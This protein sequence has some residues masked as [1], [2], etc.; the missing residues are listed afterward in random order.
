MQVGIVPLMPTPRHEGLLVGCLRALLAA[1]MAAARVHAVPQVAL[2]AHASEPA[3]SDQRAQESS[4]AA[5]A[6]VPSF[7]ASGQSQWSLR[8]AWGDP[9]GLLGRELYAI[10]HPT[11][12]QQL[13]MRLEGDVAPGV[14]ALADLD[15]VK[16][17]NLQ[18]IGIDV[19]W[20][21]TRTHLGDIQVRSESSYA[22]G[23]ATVKGVDAAL[24]LG[25][26]QLSLLAGRSRGIPASKTFYGTSSEET[27]R[28][29]PGTAS[30]SPPYVP[31]LEGATLVGD[32]RGAEGFRL[33]R[34]Y[35]PDFTRVWL[36]PADGPPSAAPAG[37][38]TSGCGEIPDDRTLQ[39]LLSDYGLG[40]LYYDASQPPGQKG[41]IRPV[42]LTQPLSG[43]PEEQ[44]RRAFFALIEGQVT[45]LLTA[46]GEQVAGYVL[47][48]LESLDLMR[49]HVEALV[50]RFNEENQRSG[51]DRLAYPFVRGSTLEREFLTKLRQYYRFAAGAGGHPGAA[52]WSPAVSTPAGQPAAAPVPFAWV[53]TC[54]AYREGL[55]DGASNLP[56]DAPGQTLQAAS[57]LYLLGN[58]GVQPDDL[59]VQVERAGEQPQEADVHGLSWTLFAEEGVLQ[60]DY[61]GTLDD[62]EAE[63]AALR[64][65]YRHA[66][67]RGIYALGTSVAAGSERVY[68]NG[69]LL[70]RD[71]DY[72]IDYE[73]GVLVVLRDVAPE[74]RL[75]VDF[76]YFRGGLGAATEYHRNVF[77]VRAQWTPDERWRLAA[78]VFF[79][80]DEPRPMVEPE[81]ARTMPNAHTVAALSG[82]YRAERGAAPGQ[83]LWAEFDAAF[84]RDVSPFDANQ[85]VPQP[86]EV[87]VVAGSRAG[88]PGGAASGSYVLLGHRGGLTV[89]RIDETPGAQPVWGLYTTAA[90]LSGL[91]VYAVA[92]IVEGAVSDG[93]WPDTSGSSSTPPGAW[94]A[95]TES[96]L[97]L[98]VNRPSGGG[99]PF[100]S[101]ANW[102]RRH[103]S[104]GLPS[105][106]VR[107]VLYVGVPTR[108]PG[109]LD[110]VQTSV[111]VA[112]DRGVAWADAEGL[113]AGVTGDALRDWHTLDATTWPGAPP[114]EVLDLA[115]L[116]DGQDAMRH[117]VVA[118]TP[119]GVVWIPLSQ[120]W[121]EGWDAV[122]HVVPQGG[123]T[124]VA[125]VP[126]PGGG[127]R[128]W[129]G[130]Q[131]GL[132]YVD[133]PGVGPDPGQPRAWGP[134][135]PVRGLQALTSEAGAWW[136]LWVAA[137]SGIYRVGR[138][139]DEPE[140]P[141]PV[142][143]DPQ[144]GP[145]TAIGALPLSGGPEVWA[146]SR[147]AS[148]QPQVLRSVTGA[149]FEPV[150]LHQA[151]LPEGDPARF[152]DPLSPEV[153]QGMAGRVAAGY[154]WQG[155]GFDLSY[156]RVDGRF[157][158]INDIH[159][160]A[161][162]T[163]QAS[164]RH[165][166]TPELVVELSHQDRWTKLPLSDQA[167]AGLAQRTLADH[168]ALTWTPPVPPPFAWASPPALRGS[169]RWERVDRDLS[170]PEPE[171]VTLRRTLQ[172]QESFWQ[173]RLTASVGYEHVVR[174]ERGS[175]ATG[176]DYV[177][178]DLVA[179]LSVAPV[180]EVKLSANFRYPLR[181]IGDLEQP[182]AQRLQGTQSLH[183]GATASRAFGPVR[184]SLSL[185]QQSGW[186]LSEDG[187]GFEGQTRQ[188][189]LSVAAPGMS[190]GAW[191]LSPVG[192]LEWSQRDSQRS[193][194][195][196]FGVGGDLQAAWQPVVTVEVHADRGYELAERPLSKQTME[197][198]VEL[199]ARTAAWNGFDPSLTLARQVHHVAALGGY[200]APDGG[201]ERERMHTVDTATLRVGWR[202]G[203][204]WPQTS[205]IGARWVQGPAAGQGSRSVDAAHTFAIQPGGPWA[206]SWTAGA[207]RG[208]TWQAGTAPRPIWRVDLSG[209]ASYGFS[210][211][212]TGGLEA[213]YT[214][215]LASSSLGWAAPSAAA[216]DEAPFRTGWVRLFV[217]ATF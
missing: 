189:T 211:E 167:G 180:P 177:A 55:G 195:S 20:G 30:D 44:V 145:A 4:E 204:S 114:E 60:V 171:Q 63:F 57:V 11:F 166:P 148:G 174:D 1:C 183:V 65:R 131:S 26:W 151:S 3:P 118:A 91:T 207:S 208:E 196:T 105:N 81:R 129:I 58:I 79:E 54:P 92:P 150:S 124:R 141:V 98:I 45:G 66:I 212:W 99:S 35:D 29:V 157:L 7:R 173:H 88:Q 93:S 41:V 8:Y 101:T 202:L 24:D 143:A 86:N 112:T 142:L 210:T 197:D 70:K 27:V 113:A 21:P 122:R 187:T 162:E 111:W 115:F 175:G 69:E 165:Q 14:S 135:G 209:R 213:G 80:G 193:G 104:S 102:E 31:S 56:P 169:A 34:P 6:F 67:S 140:L 38:V 2:A 33:D 10:G 78:E 109:A 125:A 137:D 46:P 184:T 75:Q 106:Q 90:G 22:V 103:T 182:Q 134:V 25:P 168:V 205:R 59:S 152:A 176:S 62:F 107:D 130:S 188:A 149:T 120:G 97:T 132:Q 96:G 158:A 85:R 53:G 110:P 39:R 179:D 49:A 9:A 76:E 64:V 28:F 200:R 94:V 48:G 73:S 82:A 136:D 37:G 89:G 155:G 144:A 47:L 178:H 214:T 68:L 32:L 42:D 138:A 50:R 161:F 199:T 160:R 13:R 108:P 51:V 133:V 217:E 216:G 126:R 119:S 117:A 16:S 116:A 15:N 203:S 87:H 17:E 172:V 170:T 74:D 77:G 100:D 43:L 71:T 164:V 61:P 206:L 52:D 23:R 123:V 128:V 147:P 84:S 181:V 72:T 185:G 163:W 198:R 159:R 154:G 40:A 18:L 194:G 95:G 19:A 156:E 192:R 139:D 12:E 36:V 215:G 5:R 190:W 191:S 201:V 146:A 153:Y 121:G 186:R 83:G 127:A